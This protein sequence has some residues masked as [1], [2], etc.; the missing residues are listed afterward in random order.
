MISFVFLIIGFALSFSLMFPKSE[1]FKDP[2]HATLRTIV[3]MVGE[4]DYISTFSEE[5]NVCLFLLL[6]HTI[7]NA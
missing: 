2:A 6:L 1:Y 7:I 3:M 4:F 5:E